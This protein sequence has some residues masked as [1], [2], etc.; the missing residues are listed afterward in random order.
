ML[1]I[2]TLFLDSQL[3]KNSAIPDHIVSSAYKVVTVDSHVMKK[4]AGVQDAASIGAV[5]EMSTP[6]VLLH[7]P[8]TVHGPS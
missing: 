6:Q 4:L 8:C 3:D 7:P 1:Q 5:A 2:L